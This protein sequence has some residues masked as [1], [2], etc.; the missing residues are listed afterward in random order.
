MKSWIKVKLKSAEGQSID[1]WMTIRVD[2]IIAVANH[3]IDGKENGSVI[4]LTGSDK[5]FLVE[6]DVRKVFDMISISIAEEE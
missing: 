3:L 1:V 2:S 5:P 6:H 4:F